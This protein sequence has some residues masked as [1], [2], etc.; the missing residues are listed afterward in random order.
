MQGLGPR[1]AYSAS[2][3]PRANLSPCPPC[4]HSSLG[5][6]T[7]EPS[8]GPHT[9]QSNHTHSF[10]PRALELGESFVHYTILDT[11]PIRVPG[12]NSSKPNNTI[13]SPPPLCPYL[14]RK[15]PTV[16]AHIFSGPHPRP[17][18][19]CKDLPNSWPIPASLQLI[20]GV[21]DLSSRSKL[22]LQ[23]PHVDEPVQQV[24]AASLVV[25][26]GCPGTA[27]WLLAHN[28][29]RGLAVDVEVA[30]GVAQVLLGEANRLAVSSEDGT[31][32]TVLRGR[33]DQ[34]AGLGKSIGSSVIIDMGCQDGAEELG[35][36]EL[37][38]R[39]GCR[40][41][42]GKDK[43]ALGLVVLATHDKLELLVVLSLVDGA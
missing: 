3:A 28:R 41:N 8:S 11:L 14:C 9:M 17:F 10:Q 26:A 19:T 33:V 20:A 6:P 43:V 42:G 7:R 2:W 29:A 13:R 27:E 21:Q 1:P 40:V 36:E 30:G 4:R 37:V 15:G 16:F 18:C 25:C 38:R 5:N 24:G 22:L 34:L 32:K 31:G 12:S 39:V 35:G 23:G